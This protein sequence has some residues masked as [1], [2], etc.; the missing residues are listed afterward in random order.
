VPMR[1]R[2]ERAVGEFCGGFDRDRGVANDGVASVVAHGLTVGSMTDVPHR[3]VGLR[4]P[5][6]WQ[7]R[8]SRW[9]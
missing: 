7:G 9:T 1:A 5:G 2:R 6:R 8:T 4:F 3:P